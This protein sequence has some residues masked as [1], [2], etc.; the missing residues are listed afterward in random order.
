MSEL[1]VIVVMADQD[2]S[3]AIARPAE[4]PSAD[5]APIPQA[6]GLTAVLTQF[7]TDLS[8]VFEMDGTAPPN[9][10]QPL[11]PAFTTMDDDIEEPAGLPSQAR[12]FDSEEAER[13]ADE[14]A[15]A[16]YFATVLAEGQAEEF[17]EQMR[18]LPQVETAYVVPPTESPLGP[19]QSDASGFVVEEAPDAPSSIPDFVSRQTYLAPS[20]F[21]IGATNAWRIRG[22]RGDN[23]N[24]IDIEGGWQ[25]SHTDLQPNGGLLAGEQYNSV[26]WRNHGTAVMGQIIAAH[27]NKGVNGIAPHAQMAVVSHYHST[28]R[29][30]N[31]ATA[32][33]YAA[34]RLNPGDVLLLEMHRAGPRYNFTRRNDQRGYI[35]IE[36]W[37]HDFL[38]IRNAVRRG[39][40]VVEAAGNGAENF[41]DPLY[42]TPKLGFPRGWRN[43]VS[44]AIDSGAI[45][46]GAGA[47]ASGNQGPP[48]SR[49]DFS[50]YGA[51]VDCQGWGREVTTTGYGDL[52]R[53]RS[54][55]E[56]YTHSFSGTS[57]ASPIVTGAIAQVQGVSKARSK[58]VS[59]RLARRLLRAIGAP[60]MPSSLSPLS[61]RIGK[62]PD[63]TAM[64][65][66]LF[67]T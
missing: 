3:D 41:D 67:P 15:M 61:Q 64:I 11:G 19:L 60:Q 48:R 37:P 26:R 50:N 32:I 29:R 40:I 17:A 42:N 46:V 44:G 20:P 66:R 54:E 6:P 14:A 24:V 10:E 2:W 4:P 21:G 62:Q 65:S 45:I 57:S 59:P 1:E 8:P 9:V 49:L 7:G 38:A 52:F 13:A 36:W 22:G 16:R 18:A 53:G 55:D 56:W 12:D 51:R 27:D 5:G 39:I 25:L 63:V 35:A 30:W 33:N 31:S 23:V 43:P 28:N 58:L 47:P 34:N